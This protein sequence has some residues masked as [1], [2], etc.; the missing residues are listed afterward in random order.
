MHHLRTIARASPEGADHSDPSSEVGVQ[1][2]VRRRRMCGTGELS[3]TTSTLLVL[4][5]VGLV[6]YQY[7]DPLLSQHVGLGQG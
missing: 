4:R 1:Q 3:F 6:I 2:V 7:V 5:H